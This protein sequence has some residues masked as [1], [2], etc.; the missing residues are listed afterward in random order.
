MSYIIMKYDDLSQN[1]LED[2]K[3]VA[4]FAI[5][6]NVN[7]SMG[8]VGNSLENP[9]DK[10]I[11]NCRLWIDNGI[12]LWNHGYYHTDKEFSMSSY[13]EQCY[14]LKRTQILMKDKLG[15]TATCFGSPHNNS[16]ETTIKALKT[17]AP[18]INHYFFAVD[19]TNS[20]KSRQ[21]LVRCNMETRTGNIDID[22]FK[23]NY[24]LLKDLPYIVIQGHPSFW[25]EKDFRLNEEIISYLKEKGNT[26]VKPSELP[27][28][29]EMNNNPLDNVINIFRDMGKKFVLYGA[30]QIGRELYRFIKKK[31]GI[32]PQKYVVSDGQQINEEY[33]CDIRVVNYSELLNET[34]DVVV[35]LALMPKFHEEIYKS[36]TRDGIEYINLGNADEYLRI[37][38][39]I[40]WDITN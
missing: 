15:V 22:F 34:D 5:K 23:Y 28:I 29:P 37:I 40:R 17:V 14:S 10:Y 7:I 13:E 27:N 36:L 6:T 33:I 20:T 18:Q 12:E 4:D 30:G 35:L 25:Q 19:G 11:D 9:V 39:M 1:T 8:V 32:E 31:Y 24:E 21:L 38:N 26:F 3:R 2:F 16:T